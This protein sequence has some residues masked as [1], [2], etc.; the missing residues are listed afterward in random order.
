MNRYASATTAA[1]LTALTVGLG[2]IVVFISQLAPGYALDDQFGARIETVTLLSKHGAFT[3]VF[4]G[5]ALVALI[6]VL[7]T[8]SRPIA[9]VIFGM[10]VA[11]ILV[12]LFIDLPDLGETGMFTAPGA[13]NID[14]TGSSEAGLWMELIGGIVLMLSG[15][16]L[17]TFDSVELRAVLPGRNRFGKGEAAR[18][19]PADGERPDRSGY[20]R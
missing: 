14:A 2:I 17:A 7:V 18:P 15:A 9:I 3:L 11:V 4:A 12:F 8:G 13:G 1:R 19:Q 20:Q 6:L 5:L 10:G 16:A